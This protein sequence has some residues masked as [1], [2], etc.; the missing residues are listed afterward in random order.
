MHLRKAGEPTDRSVITKTD[1]SLFNL[2]NSNCESWKV[3][4]RKQFPF[5]PNGKISV[6]SSGFE[7]KS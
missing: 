6:V 1:A 7:K 2:F 5:P 3:R 4:K